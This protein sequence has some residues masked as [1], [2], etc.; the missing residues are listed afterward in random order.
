[1][2]SE[3]I[4]LLIELYKAKTNDPFILSTL[5]VLLWNRNRF[6]DALYFFNKTK[7]IGSSPRLF[8][9]SFLG[10]SG[11]CYEDSEKFESS[12]QCYQELL[13]LKPSWLYIYEK[14]SLI[15]EK[16]G[17]RIKMKENNNKYIELGKKRDELYKEE[18]LGA[19]NGSWVDYEGQSYKFSR[20]MSKI[21]RASCRE[22]V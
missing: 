21:G 10:W 6:D 22:R 5:G 7:L 13:Q 17:N 9:P 3:E 11:R 14:I 1:M 15:H 8:I 18:L 20:I 19:F 12:I 4:K 16:M 2:D